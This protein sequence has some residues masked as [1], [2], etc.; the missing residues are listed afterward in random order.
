MDAGGEFD[1]ERHDVPLDTKCLHIEPEEFPLKQEAFYD[2]LRL[3]RKHGLKAAALLKMT[4]VWSQGAGVH[5]LRA[6]P[7]TEAWAKRVDDS[8]GR[9]VTELLACNEVISES[10]RTQF[11]VPEKDADRI[12]ELAAAALK[13]AAKAVSSLAENN[14]KLQ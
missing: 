8:T 3:L 11:F 6:T 13:E 1:D 12:E 10:Q 5:I 4:E 9:M 14:P 7:V 2:R